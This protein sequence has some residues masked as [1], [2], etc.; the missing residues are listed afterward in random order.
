MFLK[1]NKNILFKLFGIG[2]KMQYFEVPLSASVHCPTEAKCT[3]FT[4][5]HEGQSRPNQILVFYPTCRVRLVVTEIQNYDAWEIG[6]RC[7]R[8]Y[9]G[10][11]HDLLLLQHGNNFK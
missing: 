7:N 5:M 11:I 9:A 2:S 6:V 1:N 10:I 4:A 8:M 3:D